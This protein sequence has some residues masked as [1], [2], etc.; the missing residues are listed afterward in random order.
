MQWCHPG[1][2]SLRTEKLTR[3]DVPSGGHTERGAGR[4]QGWEPVP[5]RCSWA[6]PDSRSGPL[7][8]LHQL[9]AWEW[10]WFRTMGRSTRR[11]QSVELTRAT[12]PHYVTQMSR[13]LLQSVTQ[14]G[15]NPT[16]SL[17]NVSGQVTKEQAAWKWK[18]IH[19][20]ACTWM[21]PNSGYSLAETTQMSISGWMDQWNGG[22]P[23]NE[24]LF[25]SPKG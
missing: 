25:S 3:Q 24:T 21:H 1:G 14:E 9:L 7:H 12:Q 17:P 16:E 4:D 18:H 23:K 15:H 8:L 5:W 10:T 6:P 2:V 13:L 20:E 11:A 19:T 22:C